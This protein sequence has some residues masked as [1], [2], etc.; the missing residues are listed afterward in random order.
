[1]DHVRCAM[2]YELYVFVADIY[3]F[4]LLP[5]IR[6]V[7]RILGLALVAGAAVICLVRCFE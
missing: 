7:N 2:V 1:M 6:L 3:R 5:G 4:L